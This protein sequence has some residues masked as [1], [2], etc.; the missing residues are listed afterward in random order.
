MGWARISV[1][2]FVAS[3]VLSL[4][5]VP[6]Q[7]A[8]RAASAGPDLALDSQTPWVT[9]TA[10]WFSLSLGVGDEAVQIGDLHIEL[11]FFSRIDDATELAQST[12][13]L[14]DKSVLT[15]L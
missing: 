4:A 14:P 9:P 8:A 15:H 11:T 1:C 13:A 12:N 6:A 7:A 10:P 5:A 3:S 2:A